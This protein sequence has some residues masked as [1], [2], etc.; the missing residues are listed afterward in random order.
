MNLKR[1]PKG[2]FALYILIKNKVGITHA[3]SS[4]QKLWL[5]IKH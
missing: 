1:W 3:L 4:F 5:Q 2:V